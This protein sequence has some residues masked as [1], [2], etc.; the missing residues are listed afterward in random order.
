MT[1]RHN[2]AIS[3]VDHYQYPLYYY[4]DMDECYEWTCSAKIVSLYL[5]HFGNRVTESKL[6]F[7]NCHFINNFRERKLMLVNTENSHNTKVP[8]IIINNCMFYGNKN[9]QLLLI[10]CENGDKIKSVHPS[11]S[12][13]QKCYSIL[14][15]MRI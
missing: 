14:K 2:S 15:E 7:T 1:N 13:E 6:Y 11:L 3:D 10:R 4:N 12:K 9:M 5:G 8:L